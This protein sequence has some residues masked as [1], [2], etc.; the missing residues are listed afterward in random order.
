MGNIQPT[1]FSALKIQVQVIHVLNQLIRWNSK[2]KESM[3]KQ[4]YK[5]AGWPFSVRGILNKKLLL[6]LQ[7]LCF[8]K[9]NSSKGTILEKG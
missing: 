2:I 4:V 6:F 8:P 3:K 9:K 1:K 7:P 5:I